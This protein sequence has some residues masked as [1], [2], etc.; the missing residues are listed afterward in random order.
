MDIDVVWGGA[1]QL[2]KLWVEYKKDWD[3]SFNLHTPSGLMI[4]SQGW[5]KTSPTIEGFYD[6]LAKKYGF[7]KEE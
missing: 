6:W 1:Q 5:I 4:D 7:D 2:A 3:K